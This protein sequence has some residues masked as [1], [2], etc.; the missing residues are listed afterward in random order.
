[1]KRYILLLLS[2]FIFL[3]VNCQTIHKYDYIIDMHYYKAFYNKNIK[4]SSFV[5]YKLYKGGGDVNRASYSFKGYK[6]LPYFKYSKSGYD[7]GHLVP[8]EDFANTNLRLK[9][10][11]YYINCVPQTPNLNR[12][13]WK[14]YETQIRKLSQSDSL[15]VICGG[16][17]YPYTNNTNARYIPRNCFKIVYDLK[18]KKCIYSL[19]FSNNTTSSFVKNENKLKQRMSF[20]HALDLYNKKSNY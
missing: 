5:I 2:C 15:L 9:S 14:R 16:C 11:F 19:L 6:D 18:T 20:K 10:T 13:I 1:M 8:A 3:N 17:D 7:R 12:G 4:T